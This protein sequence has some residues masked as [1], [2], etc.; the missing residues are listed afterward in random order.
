MNQVHNFEKQIPCSQFLYFLLAL[1]GQLFVP[2]PARK[3]AGGW[4][5]LN[6]FQWTDLAEMDRNCCL[7]ARA[8]LP[9]HQHRPV[10]E[11]AS[12]A[13]GPLLLDEEG[14]KEVV[15]LYQS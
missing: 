2:L 4:P 9:R 15:L 13:S 5:D 7:L 8:P 6:K 1:H 14:E 3:W 12:E 10:G 11:W